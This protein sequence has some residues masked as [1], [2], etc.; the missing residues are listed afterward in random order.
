M[1]APLATFAYESPFKRKSQNELDAI[2]I[3]LVSCIFGLLGGVLIAFLMTSNFR[4]LIKHLKEENVKQDEKI[5]YDS[6]LIADLQNKLS[7]L[8]AVI[9]RN[10]LEYELRIKDLEMEIMLFDTIKQDHPYPM[11]RKSANDFTMRNF[12]KAYAE[13]WIFPFDK[14]EGD[15][16]GKHWGSD[17]D[18]PVK[19]DMWVKM[20][21][22]TFEGVEMIM[23]PDGTPRE[24]YVVKYPIK[25]GG[26][27]IYIDGMEIPPWM[28]KNKDKND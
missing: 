26:K 13:K 22:K 21:G 25:L 2:V 20:N 1:Q 5:K 7:A 16:I 28:I 4:Q 3:V 14:K 8:E 18:N 11:W 17:G 19:S 15:V 10:K 23:L 9:E 27:V 24:V 6:K 12:N